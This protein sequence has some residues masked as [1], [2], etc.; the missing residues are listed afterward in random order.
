MKH[1]AAFHLGIQLKYSFRS[2]KYIQ[3]VKPTFANSN[4]W[5]K[6]FVDPFPISIN[7]FDFLGKSKYL[8]MICQE[9]TRYPKKRALFKKIILVFLNKMFCYGHS[10]EPSQQVGMVL[11]CIDF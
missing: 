2:L 3:R 6:T 11:D 4:A 7:N 5:G 10:K 9:K 1:S 8:S